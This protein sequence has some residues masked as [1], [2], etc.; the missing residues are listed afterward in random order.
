MVPATA[1]VGPRRNGD[2]RLIEHEVAVDVAESRHLDEDVGID[3]GQPTPYD[4]RPR[5]DRLMAWG[6]GGGGMFGG[7]GMGGGPMGGGQAGSRR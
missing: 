7:G 6:G 3:I 4:D 1:T 2:R 5:R